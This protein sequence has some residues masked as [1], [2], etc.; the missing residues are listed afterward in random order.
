MAG[1]RGTKANNM[2]TPKPT[3]WPLK[4]MRPR[5][6]DKFL[7]EA[8]DKVII[9]DLIR[10]RFGRSYSSYYFISYFSKG[11]SV[12]LTSNGNGLVRRSA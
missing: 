9:E 6:G 10:V 7:T 1:K 11:Q 12:H 5:I 4:T 8:G 3:Y 2:G